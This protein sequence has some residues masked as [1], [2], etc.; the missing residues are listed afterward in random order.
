MTRYPTYGAL[1]AYCELSANP[2]GRLV[3]AVFGRKD[4][5]AF[6][7]SDQVCTA[8]QL[9]EHCQDVAEDLAVG[10]IYLPQEDLAR[11]GVDES[12][13]AGGVAT[14]AFRR[15]MAFESARA[16][17]LL[18][19]G[20]ALV[21]LLSGWGRVGVAGFVGG[22]LAQLDAIERH[23]YDVLSRP[24]KASKAQVGAWGVRVYLLARRIWP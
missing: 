12:V 20:R 19:S 3:L 16:R 13:L 4:E 24:A 14:P 21:G 7:L 18:E 11:F 9:I 1:T 22:G 8:L 2:V 23:A 5:R 15:L 17:R 10:R 6:G